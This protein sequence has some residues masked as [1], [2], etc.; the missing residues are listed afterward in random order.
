MQNQV[1]T[2]CVRQSP[3]SLSPLSTLETDRKPRKTSVLQQTG[4]QGLASDPTAQGPE[5]PNFQLQ[6]TATSAATCSNSVSKELTSTVPRTP[7]LSHTNFT[8]DPVKI[9]VEIMT[10]A[11]RLWKNPPTTSPTP[12]LS[13]ASFIPQPRKNPTCSYSALQVLTRSILFTQISTPTT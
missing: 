12:S 7:F 3:H 13:H 5:N 4:S 11:A 1:F 10:V 2:P 6:G 8:P 9:P